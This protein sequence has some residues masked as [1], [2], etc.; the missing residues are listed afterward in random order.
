MDCKDQ[1]DD[2]LQQGK[3]R[4]EDQIQGERK[5]KT[6]CPASRSP[7]RKQEE[8]CHTTS[9]IDLTG[10]GFSQMNGADSD[11]SMCA[12]LLECEKEIAWSSKSRFAAAKNYSN[13][14]DQLKALR[15]LKNRRV[16]KPNQEVWKLNQKVWTLHRRNIQLAQD[17]E[18]LAQDK[19]QLAQ[20]NEQL[21]KSHGSVY[22]K[23]LGLQESQRTFQLLME[24]IKLD[25]SGKDE[26]IRQCGKEFE[27][28]KKMIQECIDCQQ[29]FL[30]FG[31]S[32]RQTN[33]ELGELIRKLTQV[34]ELTRPN[35]GFLPVIPGLDLSAS[36]AFYATNQQQM[37]VLS[38]SPDNVNFGPSYN[39]RF[40]Y[41]VSS[42]QTPM[43]S[44]RSS[45]RGGISLQVPSLQGY[46]DAS[47]PGSSNY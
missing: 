14:N 22:G 23:Y 7:N 9:A 47:W 8:G 38:S 42:P 34:Y 11:L 44:P 21:E 2:Q 31:N 3:R 25:E 35:D 28:L 5:R 29:R 15:R 27:E 36:S 41:P 18:Q 1:P 10:E 39:G 6:P 33:M 17:K 37:P 13:F 46:Q 24:K 30:E 12:E 26:V 19:K 4:R 32:Q 16:R 43:L 45:D 20:E 40:A